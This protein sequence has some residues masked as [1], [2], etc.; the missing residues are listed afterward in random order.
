ML[1]YCRRGFT[2]VYAD[3]R[4]VLSAGTHCPQNYYAAVAVAFRHLPRLHLPSPAIF[5]QQPP[6]ISNFVRALENSP[7]ALAF[8]GFGQLTRE[9]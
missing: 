1:S 6:E 5:R 8:L 4:F 7:A 3:L 9:F 2:D